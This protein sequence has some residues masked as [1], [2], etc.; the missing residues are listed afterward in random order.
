MAAVTR[1]QRMKQMKKKQQ[2]QQQQQQQQHLES[3]EEVHVER[4]H[5]RVLFNR[6]EGGGEGGVR[7]TSCIDG[8]PLSCSLARVTG[9]TIGPPALSGKLEMESPVAPLST[10]TWPLQRKCYE[11]P[12]G[13]RVNAACF[14]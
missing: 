4:Q 13:S 11:F 10:H 1:R 6:E 7:I 14:E 12:H 9:A 3:A 2:Q 5:K 8:C